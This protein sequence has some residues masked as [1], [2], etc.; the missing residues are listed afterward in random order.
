MNRLNKRETETEKSNW[1]HTL[2]TIAVCTILVVIGSFFFKYESPYPSH[3][4]VESAVVKQVVSVKE[5][6]IMEGMVNTTTSFLVEITSGEFKGRNITLTQTTDQYSLK[7]KEIEIGSKII[8]VDSNMEGETIDQENWQFAENERFGGVIILIGVFLLLILIIGRLKGLATIVSLVLIS[9]AIFLVY[10]PSILT[11]F[12]IYLSTSI[13]TA[14]IVFSSLCI[15]NGYNSKTLCAI[16]GNMGGVLISAILALFVN[17]MLKISGMIDVD[18]MSLM[19]IGDVHIDLKA[20]VWAG[21]LIG[22][23]GAIMDVS[24]SIASSMKEI[25]NEMKTVNIKRLVVAGMNIGKD[26]IGT[27]TNTLILAYIGS[28]LAV[29]LLIF[30]TGKDLILI[31]NMEMITVEIIQAIVGSIGILLT[32]PFTV[33]FSAWIYEKRSKNEVNI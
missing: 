1:K 33:L 8:I 25:S 2:I 6:E 18:Y 21:V 30:S 28:S 7:S 9:F 12:N 26:V 16:V 19:M 32:V 27:M 4:S 31:M 20:V 15:L 13:I 23:S 5:E 3:K 17:E 14:F 24:M 11:G 10:I 22:S 29:V